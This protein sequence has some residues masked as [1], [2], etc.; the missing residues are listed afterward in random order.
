MALLSH[1]LERTAVSIFV[2]ILVEL[3]NTETAVETFPRAM[4]NFQKTTNQSGVLSGAFFC[5]LALP[6]E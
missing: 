5:E 6:Y 1:E 4:L 3:T 2:D